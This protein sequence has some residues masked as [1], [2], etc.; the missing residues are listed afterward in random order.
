[1]EI[2]K[3]LQTLKEQ[4]CNDNLVGSSHCK[5]YKSC[6]ICVLDRA[7]EIVKGAEEDDSTRNE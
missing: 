5:Q 7:I 6:I 4:P 3:Q 2:I 1:M